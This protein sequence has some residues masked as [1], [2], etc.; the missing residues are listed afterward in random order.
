MCLAIE[1]AKKGEFTTKPN[2][3]VGCVLVKDGN[4]IGRGFHAKAGEAHAEIV[5]LIDAKKQGYDCKGATAYVTLEPCSHTGKTPPCAN[6][7]IDAQISRVVVAC[8]DSNPQVSGKGIQKLQEAGIE[9]VVGVCEKQAY[10][11]NRGFLKAMKTGL[12]YVNLKVASSLDGR[13]AMF[14]GESKWITCEESREDV[15]RLRAK[16]SAIIT[17]SGTILHDN[18]SLNVRHPYLGV[19]L[20]CI[21]QPKIVVLDRRER[22]V[23][24]NNFHV[25]QR[26]DTLIWRQDLP[27]LLKVLVEQYACYEILVEAGASLSAAFIQQDLIDELTVYQ[28]PCILGS[29]AKPMFDFNIDTLAE[30]KRF[31]LKSVEKLGLDSKLIFQ[32]I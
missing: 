19:S 25:F 26:P 32:K 10:Q 2:P 11:L 5:A 31:E 22:L 14:T 18:P 24:L 13:T 12:P 17:G 28:A 23:D 27:N 7:L 15:Q 1:L 6:S 20:S 4:I 30:Q 16:S 21:V 3:A 9:V 29:N 8:L